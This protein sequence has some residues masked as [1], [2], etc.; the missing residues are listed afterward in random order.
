MKKLLLLYLFITSFILQAQLETT[1]WFFSDQVGLLFESGSPVFEANG[2]ITS[3]EGC[4]TI[5]DASGQLMFYT[6]GISIWNRNHQL[7]PN[8]IDL[9][10]DDSSTQS[11]IIVPLQGTS[12]Y[13]VFTVDDG[14]NAVSQYGINYTVVDMSLDGGLGDVVSGQKNIPLV[15]HAGEKI[16]AVANAAKDGYWVVVFA[17]SSNSSG[18]PYDVTG[19]ENNTFYAFEVKSSGIVSSVVSSANISVPTGAGY[20]KI[21]PDG[22]KL[23]MANMLEHSFYLFNFNTSSGHVSFN[24]ALNL[25]ASYDDPYGVEFSPNSSKLYITN[26]GETSTS[27]ALMQYDYVNQ[28][29][30]IISTQQ[31]YRSALQLALD[32]KIY[33][34]HTLQY[35]SGTQFLNI[36]DNPN[37]SASTV[38][39]QY[40]AFD[41]G[42]GRQ[43]HQ[44]LPN[45]IA[46]Y[47]SELPSSLEN[48]SAEQI[49]IYPNPARD[50]V[51]ISLGD[52]DNVTISVFDMSGNFLY[53]EIP[54]FDSYFQLN[55]KGKK[56]LYFI[57]ITADNKSIVKKILLK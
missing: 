53:K 54:V 26:K 56:G 48:L 2:Q 34:T 4:A 30:S 28:T 7:M 51:H 10:G 14:F 52:L 35:G 32:G 25:P 55:M 29:L 1:H 11:A 21:S 19:M 17:P 12:V 31:N 5:S 9:L 22:T 43:C 18:I 37:A 8:A 13:Y 36:I 49:N 47:F 57:K 24:T 6:D 45:F 39:Y 41:L 44:G 15:S 16:A 42:A 50:E 38:N 33:Q 23:A 20:M 40:K 27:S 3:E 46:S